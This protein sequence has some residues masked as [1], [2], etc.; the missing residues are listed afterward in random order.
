MRTRSI[1]SALSL[2][3]LAATATACGMG[4]DDLASAPLDEGPPGGPGT[5]P[6]TG[7][8]WEGRETTDACG[9]TSI[10]WILVDEVCAGTDAAD[11][12]EHF[13]APILRDGALIGTRLYAVDAT[14]LWVLDVT[15]ANAPVRTALLSGFGQPLAAAV[16]G[17]RLLLAA[18]SEGLIVADVSD[19]DAPRRLATV[20]TGGVALDVFVDGDLAYVATGHGG[21][22]VVDL[23][24]AEP[25]VVRTLD[26][27][28]F[29]AGVAVEGGVAYAAACDAVVSLD[30][31]TGAELGSTWFEGAYDEEGRLVAPAK[32]VVVAGD[33]LYVAAGRYGAVR[34]DVSSPAS[35]AVVGNC[36]LQSELGFYASGVRTQGERLFVAGGEWGILPVE[37]DPAAA[38]TSWI[39]PELI[40]AAPDGRPDDDGEDGGGDGG[41]AEECST[42]PP[43]EVLPWEESWLPP[44]QA[45]QDP[46]QTLPVGEVLFA[47]GDATRI[48][49]RAVDVR[50]ADDAELTKIG[51]F[52]EPRLTSGIAAR[53]DRV[54]VL[55]QRGGLFTRSGATLIREANDLVDAR[56]AVDAGFLDD[57][58]W[59][60]LQADPRR[61]QVEDG[62]TVSLGG[63]DERAWPGTLAIAG[64][65]AIVSAVDG[66]FVIDGGGGVT[67]FVSGREAVLPAA[68]TGHATGIVVAAPEWA[69]ALRMTDTAEPQAL[70]AHGVFGAQDAVNATEWRLGVPR[71]LLATT[72]SGVIEL[73]T[74]GR[75]AGVALH[76]GAAPATVELPPGEYVDLVADGARAYAISIDRGTYRSQL[77]TLDVTGG[78]PRIV[79][80]DAWTGMASGVAATGEAV[81]VADRDDGVRLYD[82][83]GDGL[84]LAGVVSLVE[85]P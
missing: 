40:P 58:R 22:A 50:L 33:Q 23:V 21:I 64:Q 15:V 54:V 75:R 9:R 24:A 30:A 59:V 18:G 13:R 51:R 28:G 60:L 17:D 78:S 34:V 45:G 26:V 36:T 77:V 5:A 48:G 81:Y 12:L 25:E 31:E 29:A 67:Q 62:A 61:V 42:E 79:A 35:P 4:G 8:K 27:P 19:P 57:G 49:M 20:A 47:F 68:V 69:D 3:I 7:G 76:V 43:W 2:G 74:L 1:L 53:G 10:E 65:S 14:H 72:A 39:T 41:E 85:A 71:R 70:G 46:L 52:D 56:Q 63:T 11:Y 32:D 6:P 82:V 16:H 55:G 37:L 73:A 38:C 84:D 83:A 66:A 80:V 44:V